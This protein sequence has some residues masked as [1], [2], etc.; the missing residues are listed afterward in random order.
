MDKT[1][2]KQGHATRRP[3]RPRDK[4]LASRRR[5]EILTCAIQ[6]FARQGYHAA[7]MEHI[8]TTLGCAKGTLYRYF[9][10]KKE[11]FE[12]AVDYVMT[13]LLASNQ[14]DPTDDLVADMTRSLIN[15]LAFFDKHPDYVELL[16]LERS[17]FKNR[18][19]P[20]FFEYC[21]AD[22][23]N[24]GQRMANAIHKGIVRNIP[25][26]A[27]RQIGVTLVYGAI[28]TNYFIRDTYSHQEQ[29]KRIN[30]IFFHG[31]L[32]PQ[33]STRYLDRQRHHL[34]PA[35][36]AIKQAPKAVSRTRKTARTK[37]A[38]RPKQSGTRP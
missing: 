30:Q 36:P 9:S 25:I 37:P 35:A 12:A 19:K 21:D 2:P 7:D 20:S 4:A 29:A 5:Q 34:P 18:P 24:W 10:S 23:N 11:L 15:T 3:G 33:A 14:H 31:I 13:Q 16:L 32:T 6:Y 22:H 8:A 26:E 28:F 17:V 1:R 38:V 27:I